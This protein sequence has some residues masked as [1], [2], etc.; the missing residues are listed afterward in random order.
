MLIKHPENHEQKEKGTRN[1]QKSRHKY[2]TDV[3]RLTDSIGS[4]SNIIIK[5]CIIHIPPCGNLWN[6]RGEHVR[7]KF[8]LLIRA[9]FP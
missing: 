6:I 8:A 5:T 4:M 2:S 1:A 3:S 7:L 9:G